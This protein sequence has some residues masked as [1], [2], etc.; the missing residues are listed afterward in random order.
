MSPV[1]QRWLRR[2]LAGLLSLGLSQGL[3][4][5]P[6]AGAAGAGPALS[7]DVR[8]DRRLISPDIYG[9]NFAAEA[10]AA[11]LKLPVNRWG[12][13]STTRYN[14]QIDAYNTGSDWYFQNIT[15][16]NPN[17]GALPAGS[18]T[19]QFIDQNRRTGT[20]SLITVPLIGWVAK[21]R[22]AGHPYDCG[23]SVT[24]Y[25]P[26]QSTDAQWDPDCGN[27][28]W[29]NGSPVTGHDPADTSVAVG[30]DFVA[31]WVSHLTSR[32]GAGG[33]RLYALD[34]EP[35]LW[36][37]THRDVHPQAVT[38]AELRDRTYQYAAALKAADPGAQTLGPVLWGWCAYLY[39]AADE[40]G[41]GADYAAHGN[42][43]FVAWY[44]QQ[45]RAYEQ[46]HGVRLVDYLDLHYYPAAQGV[47]LAPAGNAA[48]QALRL[49]STRSLWD[50][51]YIDESW[52]S[53]T[54]PGGVAV[55]LI[56]RM[57]AWVDAHYPG[58]RLAVSEYNWGA[59]DSLNGALAQADVLG[60]F[61]REGLDLATL[62][63][64]P[65]AA[66]PG[67]FAFRLY[68]NYDGAGGQFGDWHVRA[69]SADQDTLA[70]YAAERARD[71]ALTLVVI[72][73]T[74]DALTS[75]VTLAGFTPGA[76]AAV[77]HYSAANLSAILPAAAQAVSAAGFTAEF[78]AYSLTLLVLPPTAPP[79]VL[80]LPTVRR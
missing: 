15:N 54:A 11:E 29:S 6:P 40:C 30:P 34:N 53:D 66:Q 19:D 27:G 12:G 69:A 52:I 16:A 21:R 7:V 45:M 65:S 43:P 64:P 73:K 79:H 77:Y 36:N 14:W 3:P 22:T 24:K 71:G 9:L 60:I 20:T 1:M 25:G 76:A 17:P 39:S 56:P 68:R 18:A 55:R 74:G 61:G 23:F 78:P 80:F 26:Q 5:P 33:G 51:G 47:A 41:P 4:D 37:S 48:T 59:L 49:R 2:L 35:M 8:A 28:V 57:R 32:Y 63:S 38:Y 31:A 10:L 75:S 44:L 67:A 50:A 62:W 58:T 13:N 46:A 42:T 72:N 70:I